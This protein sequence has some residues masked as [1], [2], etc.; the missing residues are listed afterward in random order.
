MENM[1]ETAKKSRLL[2]VTS[3]VLKKS[4]LERVGP[5]R[6]VRTFVRDLADRSYVEDINEQAPEGAQAYEDGK[7]IRIEWDGRE[8]DFVPVQY[9]R[10]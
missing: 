1:V 9:Y 6:I 3:P 5:P 2:R 8:V 4:S 10:F 7:A